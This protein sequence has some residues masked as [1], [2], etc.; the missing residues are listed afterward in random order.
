[1]YSLLLYNE[2]DTS[3]IQY[4]KNMKV[5][6]LSNSKW[7]QTNWEVKVQNMLKFISHIREAWGMSSPV[8]SVLDSGS[9]GPGSRPGWGM[10]LCP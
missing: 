1:M 2:R 9:D 3:P 7:K 4:P 10:T 6:Y 8:V 5:Y